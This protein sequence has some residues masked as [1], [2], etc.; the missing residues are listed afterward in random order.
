ML[1][2]CPHF[3]IIDRELTCDSENLCCHWRSDAF[4]AFIVVMC[5]ELLLILSQEKIKTRRG[6]N[7]VVVRY[8]VR[9]RGALKLH[10]WMRSL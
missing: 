5:S 7:L 3:A 2:V 9:E 4:P 6:H 1:I 8:I 10:N